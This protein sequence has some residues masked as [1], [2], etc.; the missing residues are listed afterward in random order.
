MGGESWV[1]LPQQME[2][3]KD[4]GTG[5][6]LGI[7]VKTGSNHIRAPWYLLALF[8]L[9]AK[10]DPGKIS[11]GSHHRDPATHMEA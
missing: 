5:E 3:R 4:C 11:D 1:L 6:G 8:Q 7:A 10:A 2:R 9:P